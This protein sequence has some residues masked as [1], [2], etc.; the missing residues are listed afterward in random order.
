MTV[1]V[2]DVMT[3]EVEVVRP[4]A[5]LDEAAGMMRS[6]NVGSLPVCD[7]ERL[8]GMLTD[9][10]IAVRSTAESQH[11]RT[12]TV[13]DVMTPDVVYCFEDQ[14][15]AEAAEVMKEHE[16]RRLVVLDQHKRLAGIVSVDDLAVDAGA[17]RLAGE[18]VGKASQ[19]TPLKP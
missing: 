12:V 13:R 19:P 5:P 3:R 16:I 14:D 9:R 2:K 7:G 15:V 8:V 11:P 4:D 18:V 17:E 6:L 10:D 1:Q